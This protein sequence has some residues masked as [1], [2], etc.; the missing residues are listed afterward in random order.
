MWLL[1]FFYWGKQLSIYY[2]GG[3]FGNIRE[4]CFENVSGAFYTRGTKNSLWAKYNGCLASSQMLVLLLDSQ[5]RARKNRPF[6]F[7]FLPFQP[8]LNGT[9]KEYCLGLISF[10]EETVR[11]V[12]VLWAS[13]GCNN[14]T[15]TG[16]AWRVLEVP[17]S[18]LI[19]YDISPKR[20]YILATFAFFTQA[21]SYQIECVDRLHGQT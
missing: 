15:C 16:T 12:C 9:S 2:F 1:F 5:N 17:I 14:L 4:S 8:G 20:P 13:L 11:L 3:W 19:P 18:F 21:N 6:Y 10:K 7:S